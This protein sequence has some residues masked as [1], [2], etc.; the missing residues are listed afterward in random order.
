MSVTFN[1]G[2]EKNVSGEVVKENEETVL[3]K[4][5]NGAIIKRHKE[6]HNVEGLNESTN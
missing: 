6:K 4:L 3:V 1:L 5:K 2:N